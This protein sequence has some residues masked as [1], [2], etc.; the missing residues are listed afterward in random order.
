M[1]RS[2]AV[3]TV[4]TRN[5]FY[6]DGY[7]LLLKVAIIQGIIIVML[8]GLIMLMIAEFKPQ[9]RFFATTA[10]GRLIPLIPLN[11]PNLNDAAVLAWSAQAVTETMT[12]G[13]HDYQTRLQ[14]ASRHFTRRGWAS[15]T[16]ALEDSRT[17]ESVERRR[18]IITVIPS[19]A[20]VIVDQREVAGVYRWRIEMPITVSYQSGDQTNSQNSLLTLLVVRVPTLESPQGLGIEQWIQQ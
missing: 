15:F 5:A 17:I 1:S 19:K 14:D 9:D 18:Q 10:E 16:K 20:P 6:R 8:I 13:F 4:L 11:Q 2:E 7:R 3:Q 12:F